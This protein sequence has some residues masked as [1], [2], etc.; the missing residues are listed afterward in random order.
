MQFQY[1]LISEIVF[2]SLA[3][4]LSR[5][6]DHVLN[7]GSK[8]SKVRPEDRIMW[9][10]AFC[11]REFVERFLSRADQTP[12]FVATGTFMPRETNLLLTA[13]FDGNIST[14]LLAGNL[15]YNAFYSSSLSAIILADNPDTL[16][17]DTRPNLSL[18]CSRQCLTY[19][20]ILANKYEEGNVFQADTEKLVQSLWKRKIGNVAVA[21][22][23]KDKF[24]FAKS[25][26]FESGKSCKLQKPA[27]LGAC[28]VDAFEIIDILEI[29]LSNIQANW[30]TLKTRFIPRVPYAF[31]ADLG[32]VSG[33]EGEILEALSKL[34]KFNYK[35]SFIYASNHTTFIEVLED[36]LEYGNGVY[37]V[38]GGIP[39]QPDRGVDF[40]IPYD[41]RSLKNFKRL[42]SNNFY[43]TIHR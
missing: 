13:M 18:L 9:N 17:Q 27:I 23:V 29:L 15:S 28:D 37:L 21:G 22:F 26:R 40:T 16:I 42:L 19:I 7:M 3:F 4:G 2:T 38:F 5:Q 24:L 6:D 31:A 20:V 43:L 32:K 33:V 1:I 39:R 35:S 41:V 30:C 14:Y 11:L 10:A 34:V 12:F 36:Q 8:H 25:Q